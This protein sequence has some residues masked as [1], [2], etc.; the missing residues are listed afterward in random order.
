MRKRER[1]R[2]REGWRRHDVVFLFRVREKRHSRSSSTRLSNPQ[3]GTK[4]VV[5][6]RIRNTVRKRAPVRLSIVGGV[7]R[8]KRRT[9]SAFA[10]LSSSFTLPH[11]NS[12]G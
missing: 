10:A 11:P 1:E 8:D 12:R 7:V 6:Q 4:V 3:D 9:N 5:H 2:E